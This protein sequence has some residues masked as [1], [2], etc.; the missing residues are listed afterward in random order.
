MTSVAEDFAQFVSA[1]KLD[2]IPEPVIATARLVFL[3][4]I[5]VALAASLTESGRTATGLAQTLGGKPESQVIGAQCRTS[6]AN[7]VLANGT[8]AHALD[9][10]ETLE[11]GIIH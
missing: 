4:S 2:Q 6:A 1:I 9:Y 7:A 10:D 8:L 3:D 11:E 5:G